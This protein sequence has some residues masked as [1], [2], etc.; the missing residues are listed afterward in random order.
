MQDLNV[1]LVIM[2]EM[3][4]FGS[5]THVSSAVL[6]IGGG[7]EHAASLDSSIHLDSYANSAVHL[8]S[9]DASG[10]LGESS[11]NSVHSG[12]LDSISHLDSSA[13]NANS[14]TTSGQSVGEEV[15]LEPLPDYHS[16]SAID[17]SAIHTISMAP[18]HSVA[19]TVF[20]DNSANIA[21]F[22]IPTSQLHTQI[23]SSSIGSSAF[24]IGAGIHDHGAAAISD[25]IDF[26]NVADIKSKHY[27]KSYGK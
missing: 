16:S 17:T 7:D 5:S 12:S 27:T 26:S 23:S 15:W 22:E 9:L 18:S 3:A 11:I 13:S 4:N 10:H 14:W 2:E 19:N 24:D 6:Q 25:N 1:V 8:G 21:H 20:S